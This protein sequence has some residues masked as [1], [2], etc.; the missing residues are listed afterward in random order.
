MNKKIKQIFGCYRW[1]ENTP[2]LDVHTFT[3]STCV[4]FLDFNSR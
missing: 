4:S 3:I 1:S 2:N